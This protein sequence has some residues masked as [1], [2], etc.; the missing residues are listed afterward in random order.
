MRI[1]ATARYIDTE[2]KI[3]STVPIEPE[4]IQH[5]EIAQPIFVSPPIETPPPLTRSNCSGYFS[6]PINLLDL[7]ILTPPETDISAGHIL[8]E[9]NNNNSANSFSAPVSHTNTI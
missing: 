7:G 5:H 8:G 9:S 3:V 4:R 2:V 1:V 6:T